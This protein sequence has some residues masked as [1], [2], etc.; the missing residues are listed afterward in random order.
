MAEVDIAVKRSGRTY[1]LITQG[2]RAG[3]FDSSGLA[4]TLDVVI[5]ATAPMRMPTVAIGE[6]PVELRHS[7]RPCSCGGYPWNAQ[8]GDL[9]AA[10]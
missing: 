7:P 6:K 2:E 3:L 8:V 9:R 10:L 1:R 4:E 5:E